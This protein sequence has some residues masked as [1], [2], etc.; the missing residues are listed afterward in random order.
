MAYDMQTLDH[1]EQEFV[2]IVGVDQA[3]WAG[4]TP[5]TRSA[6]GQHG[7]PR[8]GTSARAGRLLAVLLEVAYDKKFKSGGKY[9]AAN[10]A[11]AQI[12]VRGEL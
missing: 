5:P 7:H 4:T 10:S 2:G 12:S 6:Q 8:S 3:G 1:S 9:W 11:L